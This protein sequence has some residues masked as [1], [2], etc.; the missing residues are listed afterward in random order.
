MLQDNVSSLDEKIK[1]FVYLFT[2]N[3][4]LIGHC[5]QTLSLDSHH[6]K[7]PFKL[8]LNDQNMY[9]IDNTFKN[10]CQPTKQATTTNQ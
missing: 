5:N 8:L 7:A 3:T 4:Q 2:V 1:T 6:S 9:L 10:H